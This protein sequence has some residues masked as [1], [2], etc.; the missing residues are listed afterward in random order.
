MAVVE[1]EFYGME[2]AQND[3]LTG[4][5]IPNFLYE[6]NYIPTFLYEL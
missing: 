2:K 5:Y 4:N 3:G 1:N 6:G